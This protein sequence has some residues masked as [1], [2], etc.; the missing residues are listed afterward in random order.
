M[1]TIPNP[2]SLTTIPL[3][4]LLLIFLVLSTSTSV[5]RA[6]E[7]NLIKRHDLED[8]D[9]PQISFAAAPNS[10]PALVQSEYNQFAPPPSPSDGKNRGKKHHGKKDNEEG[11][12]R[13]KF[14]QLMHKL[15]LHPTKHQI[16][17]LYGLV[18]GKHHK[19]K[20]HGKKAQGKHHAHKS[21]GEAQKPVWTEVQPPASQPRLQADGHT[22]SVSENG[23]GLT[24]KQGEES[25]QSMRPNVG[26]GVLPPGLGKPRGWGDEGGSSPSPPTKNTSPISAAQPPLP[27]PANTFFPAATGSSSAAGGHS[28]ILPP[29]PAAGIAAHNNS[30][31][32]L[33]PATSV[34]SLAPSSSASTNPPSDEASGTSGSLNPS[35]TPTPVS[36]TNPMGGDTRLTT[37]TNG[38]E[39]GKNIAGVPIADDGDLKVPQP[40]NATSSNGNGKQGAVGAKS[41][42]SSNRVKVEGWGWAGAVTVAGVLVGVLFFAI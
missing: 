3:A 35:S 19:K 24:G 32:P 22:H 7:Q 12:S 27:E 10:P 1:T 30:N 16:D 17:R 25:G 23:K 31:A 2:R 14:V 40:Q 5:A 9:R 38:T 34:P 4:L 41:G 18:K 37:L 29:L 39:G 33:A 13:G 15:G 20:H 28:S 11:V 42:G 6:D 21:S 36:K 26:V 8:N